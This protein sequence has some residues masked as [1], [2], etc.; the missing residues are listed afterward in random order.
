M[1]LPILTMEGMS[2]PYVHIGDWFS[3]SF[4]YINQTVL[5]QAQQDSFSDKFINVANSIHQPS[6]LLA[7][8]LWSSSGMDDCATMIGN[9]ILL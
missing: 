8:T 3:T 9:I 5:L 1:L 7:L 4:L 2:I 6:L